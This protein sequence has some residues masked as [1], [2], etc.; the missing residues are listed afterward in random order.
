[1]Q[2][3]KVSIITVTYNAEDTIEQTI[4][5]VL[6]QTYKNIEYILVDGMS[7][8]GTWDKICKYKDKIDCIIHEKDKGLY[9]AMNKGIE[10]A[11]GEII[12]IINGD[13]WY[14]RKTIET[15][16]KE[17]EHSDADIFY[18]DMY[19]VDT[20]GKSEITS[21]RECENLWVDMIPHP[22]VFV[23]RNIY[24]KWGNFNLNYPI[25]ADYEMMLRFYTN[26]VKFKRLDG[27]FANFRVGGLTTQKRVECAKE[28]KTVS[29][30]YI[31][32]CHEP[33]KY[34]KLI[35]RK[36]NTSLLSSIFAQKD[37]IFKNALESEMTNDNLCIFG[38]GKIGKKF[39]EKVKRCGMK[40]SY[41]IDND[42]KKS[43]TYVNEIRVEEPN[44]LIGWSG[45]VFI[46]AT[47]Y[48]D[49]FGQLIK[50]GNENLNI[51][52]IDKLC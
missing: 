39:V 22:T 49:I 43:G 31:D 26:G 32:K 9:D 52:E 36:Y 12:G 5:S 29:L 30:S 11:T 20:D 47:D 42:I 46:A 4:E 2:K 25:V 34:I 50:I 41:I 33:E 13:D 44:V 28:V 48:Y 3:L 14:E 37:V 10:R 1:M 23:R 19:V 18:G 51:I 21:K 6:R 38:A 24:D 15:I 40:I 27:V 45:N 7:T 16:V 17:S 8:D 35:Y